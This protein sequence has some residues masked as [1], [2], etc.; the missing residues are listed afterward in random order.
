MPGEHE[1]ISG[2]DLHADFLRG[3][4]NK[5]G[6]NR[7]TAA[8]AAVAVLNRSNNAGD[9]EEDEGAGKVGEQDGQD[10]AKQLQQVRANLPS[11]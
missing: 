1:G 8:D 7:S 5:S 2:C 6:G 4:R 11:D 3:S 10:D 9:E